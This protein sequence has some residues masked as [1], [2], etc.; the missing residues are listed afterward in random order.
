MNDVELDHPA[1]ARLAA[2]ALGQLAEG[3][4]AEVVAHLARCNA[5]RQVTE[6]VADDTLLV[7][8]GYAAAVIGRATRRFLPRSRRRTTRRSQSARATR[9][10]SCGSALESTAAT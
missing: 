1:S 10:R 9:F 6:G 4:L 3:E 8:T 5:C 2:F 7:I